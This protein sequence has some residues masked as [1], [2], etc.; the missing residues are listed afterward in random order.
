MLRD[1]DSQAK[2]T[3]LLKTLIAEQNS[4]AAGKGVPAEPAYIVEMGAFR[5]A[6]PSEAKEGVLG[7]IRSQES[8]ILDMDS[9]PDFL[10]QPF[11]SSVVRTQLAIE[12][13]KAVVEEFQ[14]DEEQAQKANSLIGELQRGQEA[15]AYIR[16][17]STALAT[18]KLK[19][20]G[21]D[22]DQYIHFGR[23]RTWKEYAALQAAKL[24]K[25]RKI[26]LEASNANASHSMESLVELSYQRTME[27]ADG[28]LTTP[29][30]F[31]DLATYDVVVGPRLS[32]WEHTRATAQER[33]ADVISHLNKMRPPE[34]LKYAMDVVSEWFRAL[35]PKENFSCGTDLVSRVEA[36]MV[37]ATAVFDDAPSAFWDFY[38]LLG[39]VPSNGQLPF[40]NIAKYFAMPYRTLTQ[41]DLS[42]CK[43][44][45][46]MCWQP[47][48]GFVLHIGNLGT[49]TETATKK[50][51]GRAPPH[52]SKANDDDIPR[53]QVMATT[54]TG[55][56]SRVVVVPPSSGGHDQGTGGQHRGRGKKNGKG[57]QT[58]G[59][60]RAHSAPP[61]GGRGGAQ[62]PKQGAKHCDT[63]NSTTHNTSDCRFLR[64]A[65]AMAS[66]HMAV[67][68]TASAANDGHQQQSVAQMDAARGTDALRIPISSMDNRGGGARYDA[69]MLTLLEEQVSEMCIVTDPNPQPHAFKVVGD[70]DIEQSKRRDEAM[71]NESVA[72][73]ETGL[74]RPGPRAPG[75]AHSMRILVDSGATHSLARLVSPYAMELHNRKIGWGAGSSKS[76]AR[77]M[78]ALFGERFTFDERNRPLCCAGEMEHFQTIIECYYVSDFDRNHAGIDVILSVGALTEAG[79]EVTMYKEKI[80]HLTGHVTG[81]IVWPGGKVTYLGPGHV[82]HAMGLNTRRPAWFPPPSDDDTVDARL[83]QL[84]WEA[85]ATAAQN[86]SPWQHDMT[87]FFDHNPDPHALYEQRVGRP[88]IKSS[89]YSADYEKRPMLPAALVSRMAFYEYGE[90]SLLP[91]WEGKTPLT[92]NKL[93]GKNPIRKPKNANA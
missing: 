15:P 36:S 35:K 22:W 78:L 30:K 10:C 49:S 52:A 17:M 4:Q 59:S 13:Y 26:R 62:A 77:T 47:S 39:K 85:K 70:T 32:G 3:N 18:W 20:F 57:G 12:E 61:D 46:C 60:G 83:E 19:D 67:A 24:T 6:S 38:Q 87:T 53:T 40:T 9:A 29:G 76:E 2:L 34:T 56:A 80:P 54:A 31:F 45:L 68:Q 27:V 91:D 93:E 90:I 73:Y 88:L 84:Y 23:N 41:Q 43:R 7:W 37:K 16:R 51:G 69:R 44:D 50:K 64:A 79:A 5:I 89:N 28:I 25:I 63:C 65:A 75:Y 86:K 82:W 72:C 1:P 48:D 74:T 81:R 14:A 55:S 66:A 58:R 92:L 71:R 21:G 8:D 42:N 11:W 33:V